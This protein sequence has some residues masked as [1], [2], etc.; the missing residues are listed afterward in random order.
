[1]EDRESGGCQVARVFIPPRITVLLTEKPPCS[2]EKR[3]VT[4]SGFASRK[5]KVMSR[6][7]WAACAILFFGVSIVLP[8][9]VAGE[10]GSGNVTVKGSLTYGKTTVTFT[11]AVAYGITPKG[12]VEG[13]KWRVVHLSD[14]PF[15]RARVREELI[16]DGRHSKGFDNQLKLTFDPKGEVYYIF[17]FIR[18]GNVSYNTAP[19]G[20][21]GRAF[22]THD[23]GRGR[24]FMPKP[25]NAM[26]ENYQFDVT[27]DV[28]LISNN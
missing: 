11:D 1:V 5:V 3:C 15:D 19:F 17:L 12:A 28:G 2:A 9:A 25:K 27:F 18:D 21:E 24:V 22:F 13:E 20:V 4:T 23:R 16:R 10:D 26:D 6:C 8:G 7:T 14:K